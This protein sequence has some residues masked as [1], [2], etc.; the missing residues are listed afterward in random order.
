MLKKIKKIQDFILTG[1]GHPQHS[2]GEKHS[3]R[4]AEPGKRADVCCS[5]Y[6]LLFQ[7]SKKKTL[8]KNFRRF[9]A[10]KDLKNFRRFAAILTKKILRNHV[11][12]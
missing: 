3:V 4:D 10:K 11:L 7:L 12:H 2:S 6:F 1:I 5:V 9:A 8:P